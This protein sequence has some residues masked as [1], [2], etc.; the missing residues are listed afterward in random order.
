MLFEDTVEQGNGL[1]FLRV[2]NPGVTLGMPDG[3]MPKQLTGGIN[4]Y[5]CCK[6]KSCEAV[7]PGVEGDFFRDSRIFHPCAES[8][9]IVSCKVGGG[10]TL[11]SAVA[12]AVFSGNHFR[13]FMFSG[14]NSSTPV[15][16]WTISTCQWVAVCT[17]SFQRRF[18]IS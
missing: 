6:T 12:T 8:M 9:P 3:G 11:S 18:M 5:T 2:D 4:I 1:V 10:K 14:K 17:I 13:A 16:Y 7:P 15:L